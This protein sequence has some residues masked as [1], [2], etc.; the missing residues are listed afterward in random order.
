MAQYLMQAVSGG[1]GGDGALKSWSASSADW[2]AAGFPGPGT[3]LYVAVQRVVRIAPIAAPGATTQ[4]LYNNA[5]AID[6]ASGIA[7]VESEAS[8]SFGGTTAKLLGTNAADSSA[9]FLTVRAHGSTGGNA[10]GG[11]LRISGGRRAGSGNMGPIAI[12]L[13]GNDTN[14]FYEMLEAAHFG[15]AT[16]ASRRVLSLVLG[17]GVSTTNM[18][19]NT[20]DRV[21]FIANA[22]AV[23]SANPVGGGILYCEGGALRY[24][25]TSG[26]VTTIGPA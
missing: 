3:A 4:L 20:G 23:P 18:P 12:R 24:R 22:G 26:T 6:G 5:G 11:S 8:L 14:E 16:A 17:D 25:G 9:S 2:A 7:V 15:G 10:S 1:V 21:I 13:N 19:T